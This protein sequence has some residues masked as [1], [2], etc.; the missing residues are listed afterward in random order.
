MP[1]NYPFKWGVLLSNITSPLFGCCFIFWISAKNHKWNLESAFTC[2]RGGAF[3]NPTTTPVLCP[4][5]SWW[6]PVLMSCFRKVEGILWRL[7]QVG[8]HRKECAVWAEMRRITHHHSCIKVSHQPTCII[9]ICLLS[10]K[11]HTK[12]L[13]VSNKAIHTLNLEAL[14]YH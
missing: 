3:S 14:F 7:Q 9:N 12:W 8:E 10:A 1:T 4:C 13:F 11:R 5:C 2:R 6:V